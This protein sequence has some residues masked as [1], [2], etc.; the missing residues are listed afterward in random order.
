MLPFQ[1]DSHV[2]FGEA[3]FAEHQ[4]RAERERESAK[5]KRGRHNKKNNTNIISCRGNLLHLKW[6]RWRCARWPPDANRTGWL[7]NIATR[8]YG[9]YYYCTL[10]LETTGTKFMEKE[11]GWNWWRGRICSTFENGRSG[12]AVCC[13]HDACTK[14]EL[15]VYGQIARPGI[16]VMQYGDWNSPVFIYFFYFYSRFHLRILI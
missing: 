1:L 14:D 16:D 12:V 15:C 10:W 6:L 11:I 7:W 5:K 3:A 8:R 13:V 2:H 9:G 4:S